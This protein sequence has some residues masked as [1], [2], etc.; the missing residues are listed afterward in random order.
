MGDQSAYMPSPGYTPPKKTSS[1]PQV[2]FTFFRNFNQFNNAS[3]QFQNYPRTGGPGYAQE[4]GWFNNFHL[5][6][7]INH[8][9]IFSDVGEAPPPQRPRSNVPAPTAGKPKLAPDQ[10]AYMWIWSARWRTA[11][12]QLWK[13]RTRRRKGND[14]L[15]HHPLDPLSLIVFPPL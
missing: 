14:H 9:N 1:T 8:P 7:S 10:S 6:F 3:H 4:Y 13:N 2:G 15:V 11:K 5:L 12:E